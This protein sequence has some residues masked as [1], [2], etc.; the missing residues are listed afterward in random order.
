MIVRG[1]G[2]LGA[3]LAALALGACEPG[4]SSKTP[5]TSPANIAAALDVCGQGR[6]A[7]A[8]QVCANQELA[9][10]DRTVTE[11]IAAESADVSDAGAQLLVQNQ[12]RWREAQRVWCGVTE[13]D[14]A[15][16]AVQAQCLESRLR[17]RAQEARSAVQEMGGYT[18]QRLELID[19]APVAASIAAA[20]GREEHAI[21]RDIRFPRID[22]PQTPEVRAFNDMVAQQPQFR[23]QD[24]TNEIVDY[25]IAFAGPDIISVRFTYSTDQLQAA[26]PS[27]TL[28]AV[29]VM[30]RERRPLA[31]NDVFKADSGWQRFLT[32]RAVRE[33]S[34]QFSDYPDFPPERDVFETA[35][36]PH[37]W[38]IGERGLTLLFPPLSFGGSHVDGATEVLIPWAE[39][40]DYLNPSAPAPIGAGA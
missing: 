38:V 25:T 28:R 1:R 24:A 22:G 31:E 29:N 10:L 32:Q 7:F 17:A 14:A 36:K 3:G 18:F 11:A 21:V 26:T 8:Q 30:M 4:G 39:L 40:R 6:G 12:N 13:A 5:E 33:I 35:T 27:S 34:R 2:L 37:L 9:A 16:S 15:P 23:L 19:A 20:T